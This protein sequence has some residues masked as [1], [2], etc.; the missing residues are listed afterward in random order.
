MPKAA[1]AAFTPKANPT[2]PAALKKEGNDHFKRGSYEAAAKCYT[3]AIDLWM[4]PKDRA[5]LYVNRSAARLK[6]SPEPGCTA[7][8]LAESG[9]RDAE[10]AMDLDASYAKGHFRRG[11]ALS[12]LRRHADAAE[13]FRRVL[14]LSPGDA[15]AQTLLQEAEAAATKAA[16]AVDGAVQAAA[17]LGDDAAQTLLQEVKVAAAA[18]EKGGGPASSAAAAAEEHLAAQLDEQ[19]AVPS[20]F[21][22]QA[23]LDDVQTKNP[24]AAVLALLPREGCEDPIRLT[25]SPAGLAVS[26]AA[27]EQLNAAFF[28]GEEAGAIALCGRELRVA[29]RVEDGAHFLVVLVSADA[30]AGGGGYAEYTQRGVLLV[31]YDAGMDAAIA[32]K[33]LTGVQQY[34]VEEGV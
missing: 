21:D 34:V 30:A 26:A 13:A 17:K 8:A 33:L 16:A 29:E 5:V 12:A 9:L 22:A 11:Q 31:L 15:A 23:L 14:E 20:D 4:E 2:D 27:V 19:A 10:R 6:Q 3:T 28:S 32:R 7:S 24:H 25:T 1:E 18:E